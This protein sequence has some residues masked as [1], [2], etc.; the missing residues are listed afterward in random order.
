MYEGLPELALVVW[1]GGRIVGTARFDVSSPQG[2]QFRE[3]PI[4]DGDGEPTGATA[5]F[6]IVQQLA[7]THPVRAALPA[8]APAETADE[9]ATPEPE[10]VAEREYDGAPLPPNWEAYW[11][12][13]AESF[14]YYNSLTQDV[15]WDLEDTMV[16]E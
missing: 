4:L 12:E 10:V 8:E 13:D 14:Y 3:Y 16:A 7:D 11:S 5:K 6:Q 2:S 15:T 9:V 1:V